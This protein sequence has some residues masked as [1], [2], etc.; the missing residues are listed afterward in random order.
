MV[1]GIIRYNRTPIKLGYVNLLQTLTLNPDDTEA[2]NGIERLQKGTVATGF[3]D[4]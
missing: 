2:L 1:N 3:I 4:W